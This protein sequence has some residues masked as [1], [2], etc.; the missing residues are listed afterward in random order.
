MQN[1]ANWLV[2]VM[3]GTA[4]AAHAECPRACHVEQARQKLEQG[5]AVGARQELLAAYKLDP[6]PELLFALG[7]VEL[8]LANYA[9]AIE[10]YE[11]FIASNPGAEQVALAQQAIGA[12][13]IQMMT[14]APVPAKTRT[15][16]RWSVENTGLVVL[17]SATVAV[18]AGL[19]YASH[20][21]GNDHS[22]T[23]GAYDDRLG[24]ART[25]RLTGT[26]VAAVGAVAVGV[27]LVRWRLATVE[28]RV[29][30][31]V[32]LNVRRRW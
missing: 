24:Q 20:R 11:R 25:L 27:A 1:R 22:G 13:R 8:K 29:S 19:L 32:A 30:D 16:H 9:A 17:G 7:Q 14:A 21:L 28:V 2:I 3:L 6:A 23:L 10:Y 31:G 26:A 15:D 18:G 4:A 12:A 5:D